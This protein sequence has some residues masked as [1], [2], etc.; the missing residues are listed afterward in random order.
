MPPPC[1]FF[2][3]G[4]CKR[5]ARCYYAHES[6][7]NNNQFLQGLELR[8]EAAPFHPGVTVAADISDIS[9]DSHTATKL[10]CHFYLQG[11]CKNGSFCR[12]SHNG[13]DQE[14]ALPVIANTTERSLVSRDIKI[15][16]VTAQVSKSIVYQK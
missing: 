3:R 13:E 16:E 6:P 14:P 12:F 1:A 11:T 4:G 15:D 10:K 8:A 2:A 9:H 5:G 7:F